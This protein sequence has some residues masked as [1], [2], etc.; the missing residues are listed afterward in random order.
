MSL[1]A[2]VSGSARDASDKLTALAEW[3]LA[4]RTDCG[5]FGELGGFGMI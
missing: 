5:D 3:M 2:R 1:A 4:L